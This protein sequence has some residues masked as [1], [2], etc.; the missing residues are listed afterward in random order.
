[1]RGWKPWPYSAEA[2]PDAAK[3]VALH[4]RS[5]ALRTRYAFELERAGKVADAEAQLLEAAKNDHQYAPAWVLTDFYFRHSRQA[6]FTNWAHRA[7]ERSYGDLGAL[8]RLCDLMAV[9]QKQLQEQVLVR[10]AIERNYVAWL[11]EGNRLADVAPIANRLAARR[12]PEDQDMLLA[13][14]D[15]LIAMGDG[16]AAAVWHSFQ[17][18][19]GGIVS[20]AMF[21]RE[22]LRRGFDWRPVEMDGVRQFLAKTVDQNESGWGI[23]LSGRQAETC[24]LLTQYIML[25]TGQI[26]TLQ[27]DMTLPAGAAAKSFR[28]KI[29]DAELAVAGPRNTFRAAKPLDQL[30]LRYRRLPG[31]TRFEGRVTVRSVKLVP[32][33]SLAM[34]GSQ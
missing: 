30:V 14:V 10:P 7:A 2:E 27:S 4:P 16:H 6:D 13:Y 12:Q 17:A 24:D 32:T 34:Q 20:N 8:F 31:Q 15:A 28:W 11:L 19:D 1:M 29:G 3:A 18:G 22:P 9:P 21:Q 5:T 33:E 26:Y 23:A 25:V